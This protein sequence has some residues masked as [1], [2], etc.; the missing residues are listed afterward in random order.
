M[1]LCFIG[2]Y[3]GLTFFFLPSFPPL[4]LSSLLVFL[5]DSSVLFLSDFNHWILCH[6]ITNFLSFSS[7]PFPPPFISLHHFLSPPLTLLYQTC[8]SL[9]STCQS[10]LPPPPPPLSSRL[11]FPLPSH[12]L[13]PAPVSP[14]GFCVHGSRRTS[15]LFLPPY[16]PVCLFLN[17]PHLFQRVPSADQKLTNI[18]SV[19]VGLFCNAR[20]H[21]N[22]PSLI[23]YDLHV[24]TFSDFLSQHV[25]VFLHSLPA[26]SVFSYMK[27]E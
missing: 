3:F 16:S 4:S 25:N 10:L 9:V 23:C 8:F 13:L 24:N 15:L 20:H 2:V 27:R 21:S 22:P 11:S 12:L 6:P 17:F 26:D 7:P 19:P 5:Q 18:S 14:L 1:T